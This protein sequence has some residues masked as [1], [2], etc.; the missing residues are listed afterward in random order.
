[1]L[2]TDPE[3]IDNLR[4]SGALVVIFQFELNIDSTDVGYKTMTSEQKQTVLKAQYPRLFPFSI[5]MIYQEGDFEG[6]N[7]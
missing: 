2:H 1:M 7:F 5:P 6:V 4:S 3:D